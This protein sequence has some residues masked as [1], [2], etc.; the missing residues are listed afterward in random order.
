M[1]RTELNLLSTG[2]SR[3]GRE[4]ELS[5]V[6]ERKRSSDG[7]RTALANERRVS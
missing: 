6:T 1:E 5:C 4:L 7:R 3:E 2:D